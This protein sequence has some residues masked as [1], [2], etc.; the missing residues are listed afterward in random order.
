[1]DPGCFDVRTETGNLTSLWSLWDTNQDGNIAI[2]EFK[3]AVETMDLDGKNGTSELEYTAYFSVNSHLVCRPYG[4]VTRERSTA[5]I[6]VLQE[7]VDRHMNYFY[8]MFDLRYPHNL[9]TDDLTFVLNST[10]S[11]FTHEEGQNVTE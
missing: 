8:K 4:N 2:D 3:T 11:H 1:L 5:N 10:Y 7:S 6:K 9:D